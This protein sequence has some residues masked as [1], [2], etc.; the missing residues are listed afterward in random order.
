MILIEVNGTLSELL[1]QHDLI[2]NC[3]KANMNKLKVI[4]HESEQNPEKLPDIDYE[5]Y[6]QSAGFSASIIRIYHDKDNANLAAVI[7]GMLHDEI[8]EF[9]KDI[10]LI[11]V[12]VVRKRRKQ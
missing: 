3:I 6:K 10:H 4:G 2:S 8:E 9:D 1:Y 12:K 5:I 7:A 11:V